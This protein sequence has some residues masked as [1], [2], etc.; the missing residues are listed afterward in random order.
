MPKPTGHIWP[1]APAYPS[2]PL[3]PRVGPA[4]QFARMILR[5]AGGHLVPGRAWLLPSSAHRKAIGAGCRLFAVL[6]GKETP[7][8]FL[9]GKCGQSRLSSSAASELQ[10]DGQ[11]GSGTEQTRRGLGLISVVAASS[12]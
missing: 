5:L 10:G 9:P 8:H 2:P 6:V 4:F 1:L 12:E 11:M 3:Q 7:S